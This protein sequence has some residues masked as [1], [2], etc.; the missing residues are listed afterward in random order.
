[1]RPDPAAADLLD[2]A[3]AIIDRG[4]GLVA[5]LAGPETHGRGLALLRDGDRLL[6]TFLR[7]TPAVSKP[8]RADRPRAGHR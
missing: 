4:A 6:A 1:M 3:A 2:R 8:S 5:Q 7:L